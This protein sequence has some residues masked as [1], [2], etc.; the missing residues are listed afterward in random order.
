MI[1][2]M[3]DS[4]NAPA[5]LPAPL[6]QTARQTLE[7]R[8]RASELSKVRATPPAEVAGYQFERCLGSG[9]FGSVWLA[10]ERNTGKQVAIK[11]YSHRRGLDW[12]L[13]HREVEKLAALYTSREI[14]G[15][16]HVGWDAD[17]PF[18]V[19]EFLQN[20]SLAGLLERGP[21]PVAEAVRMVTAVTAA[22]V[23]AQ[24]QGILHCD[25][26]PANVLLDARF[27]PRLADFGQSRMSHEQSPAL[28]TMFYMAPEQADLAAVPDPRWDVYATGALLYHMLTGA[29]PYRAP[30][31]IAELERAGTLEQKLE[32]YR[33]IVA[34]GAP[35]TAHRA[36]RGVD[37]RLA[38]I[39]DRCLAV[40]PEARFRDCAELAAALE[41]RQHLRSLRPAIALGIIL[42]G[43]LLLALFPLAVQAVNGA[44][45]TAERSTAA[46]ALESDLVAAKILAYALADEVEQRKLYLRD[47]ADYPELRELLPG[48]NE[49]AGSEGRRKL[50]TWLDEAKEEIDQR[51]RLQ[52][53]DLDESWFLN[54]AQGFQR[55]R[56]PP[57]AS[58]LD[59]NF[60]WR[61]YFHGLGNDRTEWKGRTDIPALTAAHVSAP[62]VS[63]TAQEYRVAITV[64][65][66]TR[67]DGPVVGVLGRTINLGELLSAFK[68]RVARPMPSNGD[69]LVIALVDTRTGLLLD[70][71]WM[72][73]ANR[74]NMVDARD[75]ERLKIDEEQR[76][77]L[78]QLAAAVQRGADPHGAQFDYKYYD[79]VDEFVT[80]EARYED[81]WLAAFWP[82]DN[83]SWV[84]VVQERREKALRPVREMRDGLVAYGVAGLL[85]CL[86]LVAT[87]WYFVRRVMRG[88]TA[89]ASG[90]PVQTR[91]LATRG[92]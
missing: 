41:A 45:H 72:T 13:L 25:V 71:P 29:P 50:A 53:L 64:P 91:R 83:T 63:T 51:R 65:V 21:L 37:S 87:S 40:D 49:P 74:Q 48:L 60:S 20:G 70:H 56:N 43:L 32:V 22:L 28:G 5:D 61:D 79:P 44:V 68:K 88:R 9:A 67:A 3:H 26:K 90:S 31:T 52:G 24:Q 62:F 39:I 58:T 38:A 10:C 12:S 2:G 92:A 46:R 73:P 54:D 15:L 84:A 81:T 30:E 34:R 66:R 1:I 14:V 59:Q 78:Q 4:P 76:Q 85:F 80:G 57:S 33:R 36:V 16:L 55:W 6:E 18:Y 82:V 11:F 23:H 8:L 7:Q 27:A 17:P 47:T 35:A 89:P 69:E 19:M 75:F 77:N 42:P 86:A